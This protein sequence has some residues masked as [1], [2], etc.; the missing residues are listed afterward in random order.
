MEAHGALAWGHCQYTTQNIFLII[1]TV[2][3]TDKT[4]TTVS[5]VSYI[6]PNDNNPLLHPNRI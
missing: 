1:L 3:L 2:L 6:L 5:I 4:Q